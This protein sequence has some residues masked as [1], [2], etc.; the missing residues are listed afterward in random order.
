MSENQ[1]PEA[2]VILDFARKSVVPQLVDIAT[3][4]GRKAQVLVLPG[5]SGLT[6]QSV[7]PFA[8]VYL[9]APER[10]RGT[11]TVKDLP[12]FIAH[13]KRFADL[14]SVLFADPDAPG[15]V[16][17]LNYHRAGAPG[18]PR[19]G[20]HR[21]AYSFPLSDEWKAWRDANG[22]DNVM[23]Q[24]DFAE[25]I[26]DH[27][28]DIGDPST[29]G[30]SA[31]KLAETIGGTFASPS[32]IRAVAREFGVRENSVV[33]GGTNLSSGETEIQYVTQHVDESGLP[34]RVPSL[35]LIHIPVFKNGAPYQVAVRLRYRIKDG[36]ALWFFEL[37]GVEKVFQHAFD[38]AVKQAAAETGLPVFVGSPEA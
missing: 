12:S 1:K 34:L 6:A 15:L 13:A 4:D 2:E 28:V 3:P 37:Y 16:A 8:D 30:E 31:A 10:R 38:E 36:R 11:A 26:E 24:K 23:S 22:V 18:E 25:F 35:F 9:T 19:F 17:V 32:K 27:V 33:K 7:K 14:D 21:T 20:D 5:Q 29:A